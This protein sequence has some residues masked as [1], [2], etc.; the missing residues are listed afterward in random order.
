MDAIHKFMHEAQKYSISQIPPD[1]IGLG[2]SDS[3]NE[4]VNNLIKSELPHESKYIK[5]VHR[6][7]TFIEQRNLLTQMMTRESSRVDEIVNSRELNIVRYS[8]CRKVYSFF[9]LQVY[10]CS[11]VDLV[12]QDNED[13]IFYCVQDFN[14]VHF[15]VKLPI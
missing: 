13:N 12:Y 15:V 10:R 2:V 6:I 1:F 11:K 4:M 3:Q 5:V 9:F 8:L 14:T 7:L